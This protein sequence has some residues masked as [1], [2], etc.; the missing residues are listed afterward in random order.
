MESDYNNDDLVKE[1]S[2]V[3]DYNQKILGKEMV[4]DKDCYKLELIPLP[5]APETWGKI[6]HS[7]R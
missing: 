7:Q 3:V 4:R 1:S 2:I 6:T 5:D